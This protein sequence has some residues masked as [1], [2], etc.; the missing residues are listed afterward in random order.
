VNLSEWYRNP[1]TINISW[2]RNYLRAEFSALEFFD[3]DK[4]RFAYKLQ[5]AEPDWNY[6][7]HR[8][9]ATYTSLHGGRYTLAVKCTNVD[10]QWGPELRI[11]VF[12]T[13]PFFR[14]LWFYGLIM[15]SLA[16][17]LYGLYR[18][19]IRRLKAV[20]ALR[21]R[22]SRDL[23]DDIGSGLSGIRMLSAA[24]RKGGTKVNPGDAAE[25]IEETSKEIMEKMSDIV[26]VISPRHDTA[27]ELISRMRLSATELLEAK[28]IELK[29][30]ESADARIR[31]PMEF[32]RNVFLVMKEAV[33]NIC[34]YSDA[35]SA[36][37]NIRQSFRS[38]D[39]TIEDDGKGFDVDHLTQGNGLRNMR[40]RAR[41]IDGSITITSRQGEGTRIHL[42]VTH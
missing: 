36:Q 7:D 20:Y 32:R 23:H 41:E 34:N 19:R 28:G 5:G 38:F 25:K 15:I 14:Q 13:T 35:S 16:A 29:F 10:G 22:I 3:P 11:P 2:N 39:M 8:P 42:H 9:V 21:N 4:I 37:I 6:T 31:L 30:T 12:V 40:D 27:E 1:S 26:W 33:N 17:I 18:I 24:L